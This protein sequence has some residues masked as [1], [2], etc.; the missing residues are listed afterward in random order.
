MKELEIR[1][2]KNRILIKENN[3]KTVDFSYLIKRLRA[4]NPDVFYRIPAN[5]WL[6][7]ISGE[8]DS[9]IK[10]L[11]RFWALKG[12]NDAIRSHDLLLKI[13]QRLDDGTKK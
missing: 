12:E 2:T 4:Q 13:K 6:K 11:K 10:L 8:L 7:L 9:A 1:K 5:I 3:V